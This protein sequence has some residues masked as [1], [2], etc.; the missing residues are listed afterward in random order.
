LV[1][2]IKLIPLDSRADEFSPEID[3]VIFIFFVYPVVCCCREKLYFLYPVNDC[4]GEHRK[5]YE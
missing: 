3:D 4:C 5:H 2:I 1:E